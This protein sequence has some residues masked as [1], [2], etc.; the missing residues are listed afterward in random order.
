MRAY[1]FENVRCGPDGP[2]AWA[3]A[4]EWEQRW[5]RARKGLSEPL[6]KVFPRNSV[7]DAF[8]RFRKTR[9]WS[10]KEPR[11]REDWD[12]G[13]KCIAPIF[14]DLPPSAITLE[15]L[16]GW[17][18]VL[19]DKKG[20]GE[21]GRAVKIWRALYTVMAAMKLCPAGQDPSLAIRK[22]SVAGRTE[23]WREFEAVRLAKAAWRD[24]K[25]ALACIIA[26]A[27]D[28]SFSPV[29]V[30]TLT[31]GHAVELG[32]DWAFRIRRGKT[33]E[34]AVG[35]LSA[36]TR[37]LVQAYLADLDFELLD[38]AT[39]FRTKGYVPSTKGGRPRPAVP[40]Q[41]NSLADDFREIRSIVFGPDESRRLMDMR[42][43]GAVE[44]N[45]GGAAVEAIAAKMGNSIDQNRTLQRTYMPVNT[46][47]VRSADESRLI[48]RKKLESGH[49]EFKKLKLVAGRS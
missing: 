11:T 10:K 37:R 44:A 17:Y 20:V 34:E 15:M 28:T 46:A 31:P 1:G 39:I 49:N 27:W 36:R 14:G 24:G 32:T 47:A 8:E 4:D 29:D 19:T 25:K 26:I 43:T 35:I 38:T 40:Y 42:R 18:A 22:T 2:A 13:W 33:R 48:G 5:Q 21:A 7:G 9:E 3:V 41:K 45:A 16:D 23:T 12:R 6:R 30:R